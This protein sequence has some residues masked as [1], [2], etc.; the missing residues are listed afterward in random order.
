M[1]S[2][3]KGGVPGDDDDEVDDDDEDEDDDVDDDED[4]GESTDWLVGDGSEDEWGETGQ[5]AS[6]G[7]SE[8]ATARVAS[9]LLASVRTMHWGISK[10]ALIIDD[11]DDDAEA[12]TNDGRASNNAIFGGRFVFQFFYFTSLFS[13]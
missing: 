3:I 7:A 13:G 1:L 6:V 2:L 4:D 8:V 11:D 10:I 9:V 12:L 5:M